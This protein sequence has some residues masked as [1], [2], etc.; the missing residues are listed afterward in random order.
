[1]LKSEPKSYVRIPYL[2][3]LIDSR[4]QVVNTIFVLSF[5]NSIDRT[6]YVEYYPPKVEIKDYTIK[7]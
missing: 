4:F 3:C 2:G 7:I 1:M 6:S 5:E